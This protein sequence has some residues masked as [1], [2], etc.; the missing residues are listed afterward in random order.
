M[1]GFTLAFAQLGIPAEVMGITLAI[2]A[3]MDFPI[4]ATNVSSWQITLLEVADS[5]GMLDKEV[6]HRDC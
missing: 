1:M 4:A 2:N 5:L 6:L 3:I